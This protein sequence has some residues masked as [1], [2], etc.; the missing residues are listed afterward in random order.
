M[1]KDRA[2]RKQ[3]THHDEGSDYRLHMPTPIHSYWDGWADENEMK[4][5]LPQ[6]GIMA[7]VVEKQT[8]TRMK[9]QS[10][11]ICMP[12]A[13]SKSSKVADRIPVNRVG[14]DCWMGLILPT[15]TIKHN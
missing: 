5:G 13:I 14:G 15:I 3:H 9:H 1:S 11:K 12:F 2:H 6:L 10:N 8:T 7:C 4:E